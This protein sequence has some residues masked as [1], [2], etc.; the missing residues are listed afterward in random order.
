MQLG[1]VRTDRLAWSFLGGEG[2]PPCEHAP[3]VVDPHG[4]AHRLT[5][6][7]G[8][9]QL[10][11]GIVEILAGREAN[12]IAVEVE[13]VERARAFDGVPRQRHAHHAGVDLEFGCELISEKCVLDEEGSL[14]SFESAEAA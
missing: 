3:A 11:A 8:P 13:S 1:G 12:H 7:D 2:A 9:S 6:S 5:E 14:V 10:H 4:A